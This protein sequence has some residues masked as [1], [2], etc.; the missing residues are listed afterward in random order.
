MRSPPLSNRL[1]ACGSVG[2]RQGGA[3]DA[4]AVAAALHPVRLLER[5]GDSRQ[6]EYMGDETL[7]RK[8]AEIAAQEGE[9]LGERPRRVVRGG[10]EAR[11]AADESRRI[12]REDVARRNR[13]DLEVA[14]AAAQHPEALGH[15]QIGK[16]TRL[17]SSHLVISYAVFCLKKKKNNYKHC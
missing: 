5:L 4:Q 6:R 13:P 16:S 9:R 3:R 14:A 11:A 8:A 2:H 17:N 7:V 15:D 12:V 1:S 10:H